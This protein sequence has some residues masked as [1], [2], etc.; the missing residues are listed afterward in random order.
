MTPTRRA[1]LERLGAAGLVST[2]AAYGCQSADR[3][4]TESKEVPTSDPPRPLDILILGGTGFIGPH[5]IRY[6]Q[7][8]GHSI[9]LFNRGQ[10]N[11][12]LFADLELIRGDRSEPDGLAGLRGRS[13]DAVIDNSANRE[14][15]VSASAAALEGNVGRYLFVSST[16]VYYPYLTRGVDESVSPVVALDA[17][18]DSGSSNFGVNKAL[19]EQHTLRIMGDRGLVVRPHY[20]AGPGDPT[21]RFTNWPVRLSERPQVIVPGTPEDPVQW[22]DVRDVTEFMIHLLEAEATGIYNAAGPSPASG[23]GDF[24]RRVATAVDSSS[25]LV[26]IDDLDFLDESDFFA[27]PWIPPRDELFGMATVSADK[28]IQAGLTLRSVEE[29]AVDTLEWFRSEPREP[30]FLSGAREVEILDEWMAREG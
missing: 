14:E 16:G 5:E 29:T 10:S 9:T 4:A 20:I 27:I 17:G 19:A 21:D 22:I 24:V 8:R 28:S 11:P 25:E 12:E 30:R 1:F 3:D 6:A 2:L 23:V 26:Q 13:F 15:W 7:S 18:D